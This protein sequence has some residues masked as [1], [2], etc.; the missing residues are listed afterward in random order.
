[1]SCGQSRDR[2]DAGFTL[3][4][5]LV[6]L[7]VL[8]CISTVLLSAI[9]SVRQMGR[10]LLADEAAGSEVSA[11]QN[12]LRARIESLR[13]V[14]RGDR[15]TPVVD[16]Q[17]NDQRFSFYAPPIGRDAPSSLQAFRLLRM[18]T[19]DLVLFS[20]PALTED[21]D[22]RA[23][24]IAGWSAT[25]LLAG[26]EELSLSYYG[27]APGQSGAR[28]QRFWSDRAQPPELIRIGVRFAANDRRSWPDL[29]IRPGVTMNMAC[30]FDAISAR[31][32]EA[33]AR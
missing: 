17:G 24:G 27:A 19:G 7:V 21:I 12:I 3:I 29:I 25:R 32:T 26:V 23:P 14:P 13:A 20:S 22:L 9:V 1:M 2:G 18:A 5:L 6:T 30:R 16:L 11:A 10:H 4:E 8:S 33:A 28:W 31:C 15:A